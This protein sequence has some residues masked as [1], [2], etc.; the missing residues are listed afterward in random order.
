M[1]F[2]GYAPSEHNSTVAKDTNR[3]TC[4]GL[5]LAYTDAIALANGE[6]YRKVAKVIPENEWPVGGALIS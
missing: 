2:I 6:L 3:E 1:S 4:M 5:E